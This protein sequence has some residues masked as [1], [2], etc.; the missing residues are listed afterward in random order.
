PEIVRPATAPA[1][2]RG[3]PLRECGFSDEDYAVRSL[4]FADL[5]RSHFL[6]D[7]VLAASMISFATSAG[8]TSIATWLVGTVMVF[9]LIVL[10]NLRSRSGL[11]IASLAATTYQEGLV[12]HEA[13][14]TL[15]PN[16][17]LFVCPC[18]AAMSLRCARG[19]SGAKNSMTP[20]VVSVR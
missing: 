14:L 13:L 10:A 4:R 7:A 18:V 19:R 6:T 9:A 1:E 3:K 11:I 8:F 16:T 17:A 5:Q 12:F 15:A 2:G 20:F